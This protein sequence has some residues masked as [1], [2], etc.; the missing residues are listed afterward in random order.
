[1]IRRWKASIIAKL[2]SILSLCIILL[3]G[4]LT[5]GAYIQE[6]DQFYN[7]LESFQ[8][9]AKD[10]VDDQVPFLELMKPALR[11]DPAAWKGSQEWVN[12]QGVF[13]RLTESDLISNVYLFYPES[14]DPNSLDMLIANQ[15]LYDA[16][17]TPTKPY[18]LTPEFRAAVD[19]AHGGKPGTTEVYRDQSGQWVSIVSA[20]P[21]PDGKESVLIGMDFDYSKVEASLMDKLRAN[22]W[23]G[24]IGTAAALFVVYWALRA[25]LRPVSELA[26]MTQRASQ[27]TSPSRRPSTKPMSSASS[28]ITLT[29]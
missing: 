8:D 10:L 27:G 11:K 23:V 2:L 5:T 16:G 28:P 4:V 15:E 17:L 1:M 3:A 13:D 24:G 19:T 20:I 6:K 22:L 14:A 26:R 25:L 12:L 29:A 7:R 9:I 21:G 18:S